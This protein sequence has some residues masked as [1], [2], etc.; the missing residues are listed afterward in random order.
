KPQTEWRA[1]LTKERLIEEINARLTEELPGVAFNFSQYLE[2]NVAEAA[3][4]V[5]GENSIKVFGNDL[6]ELTR[7]AT[8][9][10]DA[11]RDV[12]GVRDLAVFNTLG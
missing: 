9:I 11:I 6:V 5:K 10:R 7:T 3:S 2:D 8:Q 1:G 4:G 12:P